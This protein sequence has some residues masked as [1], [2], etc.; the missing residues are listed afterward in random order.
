MNAKMSALVICVEA[1]IYTVLY[2]LHDCTFKVYILGST[3][4]FVQ[5]ISEKHQKEGD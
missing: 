3:H 4:S 5:S 1:I 2:N